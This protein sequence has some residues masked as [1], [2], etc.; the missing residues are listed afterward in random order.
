MECIVEFTETSD[1]KLWNLNWISGNRC[2]LFGDLLR[3][4]SEFPFN[5][6]VVCPDGSLL[7]CL[8]H[9]C[10]FLEIFFE[11]CDKEAIVRGALLD[12]FLI[13]KALKQIIRSIWKVIVIRLLFQVGCRHVLHSRTYQKYWVFRENRLV[14]RKHMFDRTC[15][16]L[17]DSVV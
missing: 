15:I 13:S 2:Y 12:A 3:P 1:I 8:R 14:Y 4:I 9:Q 6:P 11:I 5:C 10:S 17:V 7:I 16:D